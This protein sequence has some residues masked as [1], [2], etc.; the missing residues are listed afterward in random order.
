MMSKLNSTS[1][2]FMLLLALAGMGMVL[3]LVVT[4]QGIGTSPDAVSYIGAADSL[5]A[6]EGLSSAYGRNAGQPLPSVP[7][8]SLLLAGVSLT[9][10]S[11][12]SSARWLNALIYGANIFLV[13]L[14]VYSSARQQNWLPVVAGVLLLTALPV[15]II[16]AYAWSEPLFLLLTFSGLWLLAVYL[17]NGRYLL[18]FFSAILLGLAVLAR[19]AG[20]PLIPTGAVGIF[21]FAQWPLRRRFLDAFLFGVVSCIPYGLWVMRN[22]QLTGSASAREFAFHP[23]GMTHFWQAVFTLTDWLHLPDGTPGIARVLVLLLAGGGLALLF[24]WAYWGKN[25]LTTERQ[26]AVPHLLKLLLLLPFYTCSSWLFSISFFDANTPLDERILSP[27]YFVGII[28][29][30]TVLARLWPGCSGGVGHGRAAHGGDPLFGHG[31]AARISVGC[32]S[33]RA[34]H[35]FFQPGLA[36]ICLD[37][38]GTELA[39]GDT[40]IFQLSRCHLSANRAFCAGNTQT[41]QYTYPDSYQQLCSRSDPNARTGHAAKRG[42][43]ILYWHSTKCCGSNH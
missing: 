14:L 41:D 15:L 37:C 24:W 11:P 43:C 10:L 12:A 34:G 1:G 32:P 3:L 27:L 7:A 40:V 13:G 26:P 4:R 25:R 33:C 8:L 22:A 18:L 38:L 9:G 36:G 35:W 42:H 19:Y 30:I 39:R 2:I 21:L 20:L 29:L 17:E 6:G 16:H 5:L 28:L 31:R 23:I